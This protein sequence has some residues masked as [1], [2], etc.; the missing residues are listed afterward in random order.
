IS[1]LIEGGHRAEA[2]ARIRAAF[3]PEI[4]LDRLHA[5][6]QVLDELGDFPVSAPGVRVALC[7]NATLAYVSDALR[8]CL[9]LSGVP[10]ETYVADI[11]TQM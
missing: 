5:L 2:F 3:H 9:R 11:G 10:T 8:F 1:R 7:G 4:G 6:S